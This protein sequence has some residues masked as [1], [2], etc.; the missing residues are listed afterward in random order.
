M[1]IATLSRRVARLAT[2]GDSASGL[3]EALDRGWERARAW[4]AAGNT[5]PMPEEP[6]AP[7]PQNASRAQIAQR[8][9]IVEARER[10]ARL[11]GQS[12]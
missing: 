9:L 8:A 4:H 12:Q 3:I 5:G 1:S 7:L 10:V 2:S 6:L 11:R